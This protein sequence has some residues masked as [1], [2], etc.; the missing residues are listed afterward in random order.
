MLQKCKLGETKCKMNEWKARMNISII[1][2]V[3]KKIKG[4]HFGVS[5]MYG[6]L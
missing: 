6:G 2:F 1:N 4:K 3:I 5:R